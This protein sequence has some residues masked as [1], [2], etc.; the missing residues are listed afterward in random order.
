MRYLLFPAEERV[1]IR[2]LH[3]E[4]GLS[5][6]VT[7]LAA[8]RQ[9]KLSFNPVASITD[10][11]PYLY[12]EEVRRLVFWCRD[13]GPIETIGDAPPPRDAR[14]R[15]W[16]HLNRETTKQ[17]R[18]LIDFRRTPVLS[19]LRPAW[20]R[21]DRGCLVPGA[22]GAMTATWKEHPAELRRLYARVKRWLEK[23]A[24]K[25]NPFRH[26]RD[27]PV[28]EPKNPNIFWVAAWPEAKRWIDAGGEVWPWG[29]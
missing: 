22:L 9:P 24:V 29:A 25:I 15:V 7:D 5:L 6:L 13:I 14:E 18:D 8:K 12:G 20:Y 27:T 28:P 2:F 19:W 4:V 3:E 10:E 16:L 1:L 11:F 26:C 23:P 21:R 17:W